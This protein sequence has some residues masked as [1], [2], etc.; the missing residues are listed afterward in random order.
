MKK[1]RLFC[2]LFI[3]LTMCSCSKYSDSVSQ[4]SHNAN[5]LVAYTS[6]TSESATVELPFFLYDNCVKDCSLIDKSL[7]CE[8]ILLDRA[9]SLQLLMTDYLSYDKRY[10]AFELGECITISAETMAYKVISDKIKTY[11]DFKELFSDMIYGEYIDK[12]CSYNPRLAEINDELYYVESV[13]GYIGTLE[14]WYIGYEVTDNKIIGHFARLRGVEDIG[15]K[16][17]LY[18]NDE[19][20]YSFYDITVQNIDGKYVL[21]DCNG[22]ETKDLY[23]RIHGWCYNS[24]IVDRSLITNENVKPKI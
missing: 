3:C 10:L 7:D 8:K 17:A 19:D 6:D 1:C 4:A 22:I 12:I 23:Y 15:I 13:G 24:G 2:I 20:N 9:I 16:D 5:T 14:T 18:L 21:T 11:E